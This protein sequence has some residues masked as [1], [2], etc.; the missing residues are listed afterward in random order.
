ME[1][2]GVTE[3]AVEI[4]DEACIRCEACVPA[5]PHA[6][7]DVRGDF[8][9]ALEL[10]VAGDAV[11][12]LSVEAEVHFYPQTPEQAVNACYRAGFSTVYRGV[13]GD[14]LVAEQYRRL[15]SK[16]SGGTMI[17]STCPVVVELIRREYPELVPFLAPVQ[18]PVQAEAGYIRAKHG[19][20]TKIVYAGVCLTEGGELV[21]AAI[22]LQQLEE[23]FRVRRVEVAKEAPFF[24]R[25]PEERRRHVSTA[26][27]LPLQVLQ[28]ERQASSRFRK[29]RGMEHLPTIARAVTVDGIDLGF[30]DL[31][32]CDGCLDHPLLGPADE[33][34][35][36]RKVAQAFEPPRSPE[37][38]LEPEIAVDVRAE[39]NPATN[40]HPGVSEEK[41]EAVIQRIGLATDGTH[42]DCGACGFGTCRKFASAHVKGRADFRQCPP[43]QER[44]ARQAQE[45]AAVDE[46]TGLA[47]FRVLRDR[48]KQ[49]V[50]R[51]RRTGVSFA[52]LFVDL[53]DFKAVNDR[54]G[55][56]EGNEVLQL[57]AGVVAKT[58]RGT[59]VAGRYGGDE[60]VVLLIGTHLRGARKV[61][62][63]I[64]RAIEQAGTAAGY[65]E[66]MV[67]VSVGAAHFDLDLD[68]PEVLELA[69]RALYEAKGTGGNRV[70]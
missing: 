21:D 36:R 26:G 66:G 44:R 16:G 8:G 39:F 67:T 30:L 53:D 50:A 15:W 14:E 37:P 68:D 20:D 19:A 18:T 12:I 61:G 51:A 11:L 9:R 59:D 64:R 55:H 58:V 5:C 57:A 35:H 28:D 24:D 49:E 25:I 34:Y 10:A 22:T 23:L 70:V 62:E 43:Y 69:D 54:Y 42:W 48:L 52:V 29:M 65:P 17:R 40:G 13:L 31:L 38:V 63:Q 47:T 1:A 4:V 6:A 3:T 41:I 27:G 60:F 33:L 2:V 32:P 7:I 45:E 46:L 56:G